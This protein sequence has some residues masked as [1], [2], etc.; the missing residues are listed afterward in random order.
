MS[1]YR[2]DMPRC[3]E[4]GEVAIGT[5]ETIAAVALLIFDDE[6]GAADYSGETKVCWN[7][8]TTD[9]DAEGRVEL[10]CDN[11]HCWRSAMIETRQP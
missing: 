3:P 6:S 9:R 5:S 11:S 7:S 1:A 4:C 8:Q 2:F 10:W